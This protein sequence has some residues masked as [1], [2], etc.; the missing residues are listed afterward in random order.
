MGLSAQGRDLTEQTRVGVPKRATRK[1][2]PTDLKQRYSSCVQKSRCAS[3]SADV[4]SF[5]VRH[6]VLYTAGVSPLLL[7]LIGATR[8]RMNPRLVVAGAR[9][10]HRSSRVLVRAPRAASGCLRIDGS[11]IKHDRPA[12]LLYSSLVWLRLL[13]IVVGR[14]VLASLASPTSEHGRRSLSKRQRAGQGLSTR[15]L[16]KKTVLHTQAGC[17]QTSNLV[18]T[19]AG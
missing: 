10:W 13:C 12:P 2:G 19:W 7:Y 5:V 1:H 11:H 18:W 8:R 14:S 3:D 17:C 4:S 6:V 9:G 16:N 15:R